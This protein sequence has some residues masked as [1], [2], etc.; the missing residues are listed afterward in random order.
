MKLELVVRKNAQYQGQ[1]NLT[2][3]CGETLKIKSA[4]ESILSEKCPTGY[5][6]EVTVSVHI[7]QHNS[8]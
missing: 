8:N 3:T 2:L 1:E 5:K 6:W 4:G 7:T